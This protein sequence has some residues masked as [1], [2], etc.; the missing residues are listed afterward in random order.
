[1]TR[2]TIPY[3]KPI[4]VAILFG[5]G[6]TT[7][8]QI[9]YELKPFDEKEGKQSK[10]GVTVEVSLMKEMPPPFYATVQGCNE[11]GQ[12]EVDYAGRPVVRN[13]A[14]HNDTQL[15]YR[16]AF[17]NGTDHVIRF[18]SVVIRLFDP[19]GNQWEPLTKDDLM[20]DFLANFPCPAGQQ[21]VSQFRTIKIIDRNAEI[22][23][24]TTLTGWLA[25]KPADW[26]I[27]GIWKLAIYEVP[28]ATGKAGKVTRTT[29]FE[30]RF[31]IKKF[32]ETYRQESPFAKPQLVESHEVS[33]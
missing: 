15:W 11:Q 24:D 33:D 8:T 17:T 14:L 21:V 19:A 12:P 32:A 4:I 1:M 6:P 16:F 5:C 9:R 31:V 3:L 2:Q 18:N 28:V 13:V 27:P 30:Y 7:F 26:R 23:P 25:F 10:E 22:L 20:A 29:R